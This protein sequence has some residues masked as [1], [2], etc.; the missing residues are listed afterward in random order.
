LEDELFGQP[1]PDTPFNTFAVLDAAN[2]ANLPELLATSGLEHHCLFIGDALDEMAEVAPWVVQL[3]PDHRL[4]RNLFTEGRAAWQLWD[5]NPGMILRAPRSCEDMKKHL[6]KFLKVQDD[7]GKWFY[8]RFWEGATLQTVAQS[9]DPGD[10][11]K[12]YCDGMVA[13]GRHATPDG[14]ALM[15]S[16]VTVA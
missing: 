15:K 11:G 4:T 16:W 8:F 10:L 1:D 7:G 14:P 5:K 9:S 2:V 13:Y 12:L 6:R 3:E